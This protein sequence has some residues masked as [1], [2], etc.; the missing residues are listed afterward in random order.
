MPRFII[1]TYDGRTVTTNDEELATELAAVDHI[2]F[3]N[4]N[5][6]ALGPD[7]YNYPV[8]DL[9]EPDDIQP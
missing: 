2:V 6:M 4:Q 5:G 3:D 9:D 1:F 8:E 7:G